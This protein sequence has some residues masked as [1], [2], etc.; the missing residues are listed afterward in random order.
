MHSRADFQRLPSQT[1]PL[2]LNL[3][4]LMCRPQARFEAVKVL[5]IAMNAVSACALETHD[6]TA[7]HR[8]PLVAWRS[9]QRLFAFDP[10]TILLHVSV[11]KVGQRIRH[12]A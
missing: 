1:H 4:L 10:R 5:R 9:S 6:M 7:V 8:A 11:M 2:S 3:P 12:T